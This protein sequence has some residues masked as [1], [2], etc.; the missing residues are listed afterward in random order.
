MHVAA[1]T[2]PQ[3]LALMNN[4]H[5]YSLPN[6][7]ESQDWFA[8]LGVSHHLTSNSYFSHSKKSYNGLSHIHVANG[9]L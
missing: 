5:E 4:A 1:T 8:D 2:N 3:A 7:I 9:Q 6:D